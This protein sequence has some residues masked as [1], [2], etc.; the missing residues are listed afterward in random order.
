MRISTPPKKPTKVYNDVKGES[1]EWSFIGMDQLML[2]MKVHKKIFVFRDIMDLAPLN[3]SASLREMVITS[4]EDLQRLYPRII[5]IKKVT[6]IKD[7]SIDQGLAYLCEGLK[8]LGES[9][10]KKNDF[11]D[12]KNC[13]LQITSCKDN[14]NMQQLGKTMLATLDCLIKIASEKFDIMEEDSPKKVFNS[15]NNSD[16]TP[17]CVLPSPISSYTS[18]LWSLRI[19]AVGKLKP[20]D[21][22]RLSYHMSPQLIE[23]Q[24]NKIEK[25]LTKDKEKD[26]KVENHEN[27][28][29]KDLVFDLNTIEKLD[30][31]MPLPPPP[32]PPLPP[33]TPQLPPVKIPPPPPP[34]P[35]SLGLSSVAL[36]P[37]PPLSMKPGSTPAPAP[38]PPMLRGNGGSAPPPPPLGAGRSLRARATTK[39]KRST[40]LGNLYRTLKG[41]VEGSSLKGKSSSGRNTA[42][43]AKNTGGKQ[44]MADA[45][46][47]MTKRSSYFQQIEEDVQKY[48][49]HIIELRSSITNFKTKEMTELIKFHKEVESVFEKLTDESQVLSRFE[50]FPSKK[51]EAIRMAAALFNKLDSI[52]NELQNVN[53]VTPVTQVLD[54]IERYFNKI[55][56]ELDALERTKDEEL[57]K[58]KGHNI[59]F[60][61]YILVKIKEAMVDVSS[62]CME[63]ALKERRIN[64]SSDG[65]R[66]ECGGKLLWRAFQFAFRVYTFAGGHDDRADKLT[67]EL[68]KEIESDPN[69][70]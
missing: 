38:P 5:S 49:K 68:A 24:E 16:I 48:T 9:W 70:P 37:P 65:K 30:K 63:L 50:G 1:M 15:S 53:I 26:H 46:A 69:Q 33:S 62:N 10:L 7:K 51:L 28:S 25:E 58:F 23:R 3:T 29:I 54:K 40:Q 12:N 27:D 21:L 44:G 32:P 39:L 22:K 61:F 56:T 47:E 18:T 4:L 66:K 34:P 17:K 52:L 35:L 2:M 59:E 64:N 60:D 57:K 36:P 8:C 31:T 67:R 55:K 45:L 19:Q 14:T 20:I 42:I 13:E 11:M 41:K 43:G 6:N